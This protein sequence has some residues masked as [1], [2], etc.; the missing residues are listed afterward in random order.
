ME[1]QPAKTILK[2]TTQRPFMGL[3]SYEEINK[4]QF[5]GRNAEIKE[6][7]TL[8]ETNRLTIVFGKSGI[9]KTSLIK[10]G[11]I[12]Q[13]QNNI[14]PI[15]YGSIIFRLTPLDQARELIY[16]KL[17]D[18]D[19]AV[20][21]LGSNTLWEYFRNLTL[22]DDLLTPLLIFDQFEEIFTIGKNKV[23]EVH[24]FITELSDLAENRV[25][26]IVQEEWKKKAEIISSFGGKPNFHMVISLREVLA[27]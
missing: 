23:R 12:P 8:V 19:P 5:G 9:G 2:E 6:L 26:V 18:R 25:P 16:K 27:T 14:F 7:Y 13:L 11:L 4:E 21:E 22:M 17:K 3:R 15:I 1:Q 24:D 20:P 10:A